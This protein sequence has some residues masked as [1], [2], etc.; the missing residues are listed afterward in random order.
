MKAI[1]LW[2]R[3]PTCDAA[4]A[5]LVDATDSKSVSGDRVGVRFPSAAPFFLFSIKMTSIRLCTANGRLAK[6]V[7]FEYGLAIKTIHHRRHS[8]AL[9]LLYL[10]LAF[11]ADASKPFLASLNCLDNVFKF[12]CVLRSEFLIGWVE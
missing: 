10:I 8:I 2:S 5:E 3:L 1:G 12:N 11:D 9:I 4:V 7:V 6:G